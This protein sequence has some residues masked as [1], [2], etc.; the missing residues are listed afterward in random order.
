MRPA[1][2][3]SWAGETAVIVAS[4]PSAK[5][6]PLHL[7][8]GRA[9][10]IAINTSIRLVPWADVLYAADAL[11]WEKVW[12][13]LDFP[14][15]GLKVGYDERSRTFCPDV[16]LIRIETQRD[17][18]H[19]ILVDE[20]GKLGNGL[21]GGFQAINLAVQ[22]GARRIVLVG[23]DMHLHRGEHWHGK[24]PKGMNNPQPSAMTRWRNFLEWQ[25]PKLADMGIEVLN[26]TP[27]SA[28]QAY[29]FA[30]LADL[31]PEELAA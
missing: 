23:Y 25:A 19:R 5:A 24:H 16:R 15:P 17:D 8:R 31:Y 18:R 10:T 13:T 26:A 2:F 6:A 11:W 30:D 1:W 9:W 4:G 21:N 28:L 12:P 3:P 20:P 14:V 22:F 7:V 27:G 29:R